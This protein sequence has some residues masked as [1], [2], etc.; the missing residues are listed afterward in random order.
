MHSS[1]VGLD[2]YVIILHKRLYPYHTDGE[3][4]N[5]QLNIFHAE[6]HAFTFCLS[7]NSMYWYFTVNG[8]GQK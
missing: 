5:F 2:N 7:S 3:N 6:L 1:Q 4:T 8:L